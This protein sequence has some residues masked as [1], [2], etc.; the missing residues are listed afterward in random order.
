MRQLTATALETAKVLGA[1]YADIRIIETRQQ[2]ISI[3]NGSIGGI[4][5]N[6][7]MGFGVRVIAA[8]AWGFASSAIVT[9]AEIDR[10]AAQAVSIAKASARVKAADVRLAP[11]PVCT[12][13]WQT[14]YVIDPFTVSIEDKLALLY[15]ID[16]ILRKDKRIRV[17]SGGMSFKGEHQWLATS[18]GTF[19]D[20]KLLRSGA[21]YSAT[22]VKD[23][24][25]QIRSYPAS[26]RGQ[27]ATM[28]YELVTSLKLE[29]HADRVREEAI[30]LLTAPQCPSGKTDLILEGH[31]LALQIHESVGHPSELDRVIGME[32]NYAGTSFATLEKLGKFRYGSDIVNL[33]A[34]GTAPTGLGTIGY[35]D[36]GVRAQRWHIVKNGIFSGYQTNR[37]VAHVCGDERSRGCCRADGWSNIP[38][39]RNNNLSLMPGDWKLDDLI[40]DT[41]KGVYMLTNKSWS[42]DQMRLNFQF[43]AEIAHEIKNGK[44]GRVFRNPTYQGITPEFWGS[45]DAICNED[46]W[47]LWGV[48]SCGKG[49][50]GQTAEMSHGAAP[51]RFRNVTVGIVK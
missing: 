6:Y 29:D 24:E 51:T 1:T 2:D 26:F 48:P 23:G 21:G 50:P 42:I 35:D 39:V 3:K 14:P 34:D 33:V 22:A 12:D 30:A 46:H 40:A 15:R 20:Q 18:E 44:L 31:Q 32:A 17:A 5:D 7:D 19:I 49:Q 16:K 8:G 10:V 4:G 47:I 11:E 9:K 37:E 25:A 36:D 13:R 27:Y 28:G 38:M 43:G 41:K 45:C